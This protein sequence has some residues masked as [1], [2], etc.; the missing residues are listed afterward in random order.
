[1]NQFAF[2]ESHLTEEVEK[3]IRDCMK[4]KDTLGGVFETI[5]LGL[6]PGLGSYVHYDRKLDGIIAQAMMSI[7]AM[8]AVEIGAGIDNARL[9]GTAVHDEFCLKGDEIKRV[10][11]RAGGLEGGVTNGSPLIIRTYMKP[12]S[13]TLTPRASVD[14]SKNQMST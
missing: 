9:R 14:L 2:A 3:Q 1:T 12:I 7:P 10:S 4:A 8:K 11:N 13:T 5:A 6:P